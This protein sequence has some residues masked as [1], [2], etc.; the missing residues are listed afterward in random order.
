MIR[1][2]LFVCAILCAILLA[3]RSFA[4]DVWLSLNLD[5][6]T[7]GNTSSDG[8]WTVVGK[9]DQFGIAGVFFGLSPINFSGD[10]LVPLSVFDFRSFDPITGGFQIINGVNTP[11]PGTIGVGVIG[12]SYPSTYVDPV[13]LAIL[14]SNPDIGSFTGGV[15][16]ATGTFDPGSIPEFVSASGL[17]AAD[18]NLFPDASGTFPAVAADNV[19][20][21]VCFVVPEP[22]AFA[23]AIA[24][25]CLAMGRRRR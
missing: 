18:A 7:Q 16:L 19:F 11:G 25:I 10:F 6:N 4:G 12:G 8:T 2:I 24:A 23:L 1:S 3:N 14:G 5:F 9:A 20:T 13:N 21:T 22:T 17:P 15:A